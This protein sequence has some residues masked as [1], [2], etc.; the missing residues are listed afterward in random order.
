M[1]GR[2]EWAAAVRAAFV[3]LIGLVLIAGC[4][5]LPP[6][7]AD[8]PKTA[9]SAFDQPETT[10]LGRNAAA[11]TSGH[12]G[13]SGFRLF[14]RGV[15]GLLL[16]TQLIRQAD[17]ALD[18]QY[19]IF[20]EDYTGKVLLAELLRAADRGVRVRLLIDDLNS[21]GKPDTRATLAALSKHEK[22]E[23]R[24]F[25]PFAYRGDVLLF[26]RFDELL[27]A[28][29]INHRMHNKLMVADGAVAVVGGRNVADEYFGTGAVTVR[30]A[31]FDVAA[32]GPVVPELA[33]S[34]DA[35]WN[36]ALAIPQEAVAPIAAQESEAEA[37]AVLRDNLAN[38]DLQDIVRRIDKGDPLTGM[39]AGGTPLSWA[40]ALVV[41]DPPEKA[42]PGS[43]AA[44]VSPTAEVLGDR[45]KE[46]VRE[47]VIISPYFIPGPT[48]LAVLEDLRKRGAR[49]RVVTN[50]LASTDVPVVHSAYRRYRSPLL[51]AGVEIHEVRP[52]RGQPRVER[53]SFGSGS[54]G[55]GAPFALHAKAF[56]FD[57][58]RVFLGSA[59]LD[60]RSLELNT[61][62]GLLIE[63]P[64][65]AAQII[66]RF[67]EFAA[68]PNSYRVVSESNDA[69]GPALRWQT[70][71]DGKMIEWTYEP[72]TTP[73]QRMK[74]DLYSFLPIEGQL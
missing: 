55:S 71:V 59:N 31:D 66:A 2:I 61:E 26:H 20:V 64:E 42:A 9:S 58:Q 10:N 52:V 8:Y 33:K 65:L 57:R 5:T 30:F 54:G 74:V 63:S 17:R 50:S 1:I 60:P 40:S 22:I 3:G 68:S 15:D 19:Y 23:V 21:Y 14:P 67:D 18:I 11:Q 43:N 47:F 44:L 36:C 70:S 32:F 72:D 28:P 53:E 13:L 69:F 12:P 16:R 38:A 7:G 51:E 6:P 4:A 35:Y 39:L 41:A 48:G 49:V 27:N 24:L 25:N 46:V 37:H 73:W 29:R 62:V 56:V 45:M 34:F